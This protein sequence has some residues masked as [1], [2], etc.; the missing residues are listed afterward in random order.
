[1]NGIQIEYL[2]GLY[3]LIQSISYSNGRVGADAVRLLAGVV[4]IIAAF[5]GASLI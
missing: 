3:F 5:L 2:L 1:M 4:L